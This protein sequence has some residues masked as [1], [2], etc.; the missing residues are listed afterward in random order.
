[1]K[2]AHGK[3]LPER[4]ALPDHP[5][6]YNA[7][8][9][10]VGDAA[11]KAQI[12]ARRSLAQEIVESL[13]PIRVPSRLVNPHPAVAEIIADPSR[14]PIPREMRA[15]LTKPPSDCLRR[16]FRFLNVIARAEAQGFTVRGGADGGLIISS[17]YRNTT[18]RVREKLKRVAIQLP[19]DPHDRYADLTSKNRSDDGYQL[20]PSGLLEIQLYGGKWAEEPKDDLE[21]SL[22][23]LIARLV[24]DR[25][26]DK[27]RAASAAERE[28]LRQIESRKR[29]KAKKIA[30][31]E[32]LAF[33]EFLEM[34]VRWT[35]TTQARAFVAAIGAAGPSSANT[36][37]LEWLVSKL[38]AHDPLQ[39]GPD[40]VLE[41]LSAVRDDIGEWKDMD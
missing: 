6:G 40:K 4:P 28:R 16:A 14:W 9:L 32:A 38:D 17:E 26:Y 20:Q 2:V 23:H 34:S 10:H 31:Q 41:R 29:A 12:A 15:A 24:S 27:E 5:S 37:T 25:E 30:D 21:A 18:I 7:V 33:G 1:M 39:D 11:E 35:A 13:G 8:P 3:A 22:P 36:S 19:R